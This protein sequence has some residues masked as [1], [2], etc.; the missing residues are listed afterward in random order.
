MAIND[1]AARAAQREELAFSA[2]QDIQSGM[3]KIQELR[4]DLEIVRDKLE[5][6]ALLDYP[7]LLDCHAQGE[8]CSDK[9]VALQEIVSERLDNAIEFCSELAGLETELESVISHLE[10]TDFRSLSSSHRY[11]NV[12]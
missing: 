3:Y 6:Q 8:L 12:S 7:C 10:L 2:S 1:S 9:C 5:T 4:E 11:G